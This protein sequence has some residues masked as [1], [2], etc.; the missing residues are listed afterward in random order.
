M[1]SFLKYQITK[2]DI[3]SYLSNLKEANPSEE[4][5]LA[6]IIACLKQP[7]V[8]IPPYPVTKIKILFQ[9]IGHYLSKKITSYADK[10]PSPPRERK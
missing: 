8:H 1:K 9:L 3:I 7:D 4:K 5:E 2:K 10:R 6:K